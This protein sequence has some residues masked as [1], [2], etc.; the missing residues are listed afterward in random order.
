M[1]MQDSVLYPAECSFD[2]SVVSKPQGF[3]EGFHD[4]GYFYRMNMLIMTYLKSDQHFI[5]NTT[6][7]SA[8]HL[9]GH[10]YT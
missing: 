3:V 9:A 1:F 8:V 10:T 2:N 5:S 6:T 4:R 7:L